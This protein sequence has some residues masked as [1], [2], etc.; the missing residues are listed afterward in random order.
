[1]NGMMDASSVG[2]SRNAQNILI[3]KVEAMRPFGVTW[4][5]EIK[6]RT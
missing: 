1:M 2:E 5:Y 6:K 4:D 3:G